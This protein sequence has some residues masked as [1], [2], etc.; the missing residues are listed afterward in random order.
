MEHELLRQKIKEKYGSVYKFANVLGYTQA[1]MCHMLKGHRRILP[2]TQERM[3][4]LLDIPGSDYEKY[5]G[6]SAIQRKLLTD[7]QKA[8]ICEKYKYK[9]CLGCP[10]T[11]PLDLNWGKYHCYKDIDMLL[12]DVKE[13]LNAK[14][15][16]S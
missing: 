6:T 15:E 11:L 12:Q 10:L 3:A 8:R 1:W 7:E 5:F 4:K 9:D 2:D 13:Y 14:V 16:V